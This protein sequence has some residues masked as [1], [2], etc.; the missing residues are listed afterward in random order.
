MDAARRERSRQWLSRAEILCL[1]HAGQNDG[2]TD[3]NNRTDNET[4]ENSYWHIALGIPGF[5][6]CRG[7]RIETY[8]REK[9]CGCPASDPLEAMGCKR[10]P[11]FRFHVKRAHGE[12]EQN[13]TQLYR[14]HD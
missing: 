10:R 11:V 2:D 8:I 3:V 1:Q 12:E 13:N 9:N 4:G 14:D 7:Y 5:F 6:C